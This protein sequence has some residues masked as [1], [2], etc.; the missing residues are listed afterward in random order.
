MLDLQGLRFLGATCVSALHERAL[1]SKHLLDR[2]GLRFLGATCVS[3]LHERA[4][5]ALLRCMP[6]YLCALSRHFIYLCA[7]CALHPKHICWTYT[8]RCFLRAT[9]VPVLH[10]RALKALPRFKPL[11]LCA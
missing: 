11:Y 7:L 1:H 10:E 2:Q 3:A 9:C 4:L 8:V 6:L 5:Q